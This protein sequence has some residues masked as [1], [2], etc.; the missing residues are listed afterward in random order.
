MEKIRRF[1]NDPTPAG[2]HNRSRAGLIVSI[3][4][5]PIL[6]GVMACFV[7]QVPI[8]NPEKIMID[9]AVTGAWITTD[10]GEEGDWVLVFEPYD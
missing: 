5:M 3:L 10:G 1:L 9:H 7:L 2:C 6:L 8:G 4:I